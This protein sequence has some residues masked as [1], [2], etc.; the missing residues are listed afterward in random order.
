MLRTREGSLCWTLRW[1][2]RGSEEEQMDQLMICKPVP[3]EAILAV[4]ELII[5]EIDNECDVFTVILGVWQCSAHIHYTLPDVPSISP[6]HWKH[7]GRPWSVQLPWL[8]FSSS[9]L[10]LAIS[11]D[12]RVLFFSITPQA[13]FVCFGSFTL[14]LFSLLCYHLNHDPGLLSWLGSSANLL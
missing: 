10:F 6:Y 11:F 3:L 7:N 9:L 5:C 4:I 13:R 1:L 14:L 2:S 8:L 12:S